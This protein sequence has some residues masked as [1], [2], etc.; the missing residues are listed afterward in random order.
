MTNYMKDI[1]NDS[2]PIWEECINSKFV[3]G[4][5]NGTLTEDQIVKYIVEDT[6]YLLNYAK[7]YAYLI[8][9]CNTLEEIRMFYDILAFVNEGETSVRRE[10][11]LERGLKEDVVETTIPDME[12]Q[13]Y[14]D[15]MMNWCSCGTLVEGTMSILPCMLSYGYIFNECYKRYPNMLKNNPFKH[16]LEGYIGNE[17]VEGCKVWEEFGNKLMNKYPNSFEKCKEIFR[18]SSLREKAFWEMS[19]NNKLDF[20]K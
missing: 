12:S 2:L 18:F 16:I 3:Q 5:V 14:I 9:K 4:L 1:I 17:M 20:R 10:F 6:R 13:I 8:T 19:F 11:I 7:C 15:S